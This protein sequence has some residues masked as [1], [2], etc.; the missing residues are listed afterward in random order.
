MNLLCV[1]TFA[2]LP[3]EIAECSIIAGG[4]AVDPLK[5]TDIDVFVMCFRGIADDKQRQ[6]ALFEAVT[7]NKPDP[8]LDLVTDYESGVTTNG[9]T[10]VCTLGGPTGKNIQ[11]IDT[12]DRTP[13]EIITKFDLD[14]HAVAYDYSGV[15]YALPTHTRVATKINLN[16]VSNPA[17]TLI[18]YRKLCLRYEITPDPAVL[19]RLGSMPDPV[20]QMANTTDFDEI[21][22]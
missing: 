11:I 13:G 16:N 8:E 3:K 6:N 18:R 19:V 5:A 2:K 15:Q 22:F 9:T 10:V 21:P 4:A 1:S 12:K 17:A 14:I 7:G 20:K